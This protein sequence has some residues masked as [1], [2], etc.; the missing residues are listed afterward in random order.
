MQELTKDVFPAIGDGYKQQCLTVLNSIQKRWSLEQAKRT[1]VLIAQVMDDAE[2]L[3]LCTSSPATSVKK[4]V[5]GKQTVE[6]FAAIGWSELPEL[7]G[8]LRDNPKGSDPMTIH[9]FWILLL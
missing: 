9:G 1:L 7:L 6:N 2:S 3:D 8:A 4:I 5:P